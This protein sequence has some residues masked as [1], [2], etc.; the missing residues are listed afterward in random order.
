M[1]LLDTVQNKLIN[2]IKPKNTLSQDSKGQTGSSTTSPEIKPS[3]D[4]D[5]EFCCGGCHEKSND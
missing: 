5:D 1:T 3:A 4:K 2:F